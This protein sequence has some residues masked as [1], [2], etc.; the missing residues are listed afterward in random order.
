MRGI[1]KQESG[2]TLLELLIV[3]VIIGILAVLIIPN[4]VSGPARARD[5]Q[6]KSDMRNV[7]T[8]L[9]TYFNDNNQYPAG[10]G[11]A[12]YIGLSS[13]LIPNYIKVLPV[14][15]KAGTQSAPI[16]Q[17]NATCSG[18]PSVCTSYM[19]Q[20]TLENTSDPQAGAG[21]T[22]TVTSVN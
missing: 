13:T 14:D 10:S 8:A 9:E 4:L 11:T 18:S 2:F 6:R 21:G 5:S 3:L 22:Y 1:V 17:Y 15:P 16:Y 7:K 19:L 12:G 20:T